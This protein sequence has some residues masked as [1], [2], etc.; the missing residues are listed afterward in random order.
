MDSSVTPRVRTRLLTLPKAG[1][2]D[3]EYEDAWAIEENRGLYVVTDGASDSAYAGLWAQLLARRFAAGLP[4]AS[5]PPPRRGW[6]A[7]ACAEWE[8]TVRAQPV[9]WYLG[10][11][12]R[13]GAFA[14]SVALMRRPPVEDGSQHWGA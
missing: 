1:K 14:T 5:D 8:R 6:I 9:P 12:T 7:P 11:K 3:A 13:E 10:S 4:E 2:T